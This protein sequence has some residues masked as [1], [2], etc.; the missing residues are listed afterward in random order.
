ML[1][2]FLIPNIIFFFF[3]RSDMTKRI[4]YLRAASISAKSVTSPARQYDIYLLQEEIKKN[5]EDASQQQ[6]IPAQ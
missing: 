3:L 4:V 2:Y 5:L 6:A 1:E